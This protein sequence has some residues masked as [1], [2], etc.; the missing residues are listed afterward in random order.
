MDFERHC[1][2]IVAQTALLTGYLDG[3]D[4]KVQVSTCPGWNASQLLRH[5]DGGHRWAA[6]IVST[7][8]VQPPPD[9]ALRDL[10]GYTD[11][12]PTLLAASLTDGASL[13]AAALREAG[14]KAQMWC[15]VDGGGAA[16]YARRFAHETAIH[17]ADAALALGTRFVIDG[18]VAAD[19]I[20]EWLELG[21]LPFHFEVHPQMRELLEPGSTIGLQATDSDGTWLLD[22]TGDVITWRRADEPSAAQI[23]APITDAVWKPPVWI[24][25]SAASRPR[26]M[27]VRPHPCRRRSRVGW[28]APWSGPSSRLCWRSGGRRRDPTIPTDTRLIS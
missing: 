1:A 21:C 16:F 7:R 9:V 10:S 14:P 22:L 2:E 15:P 11:A 4:L 8:A 19:G 6:E 28:R 23:A 26:A 3:A 25:P 27:S 24:A 12:D 20:D 13:L 18:D 5:V 17:R